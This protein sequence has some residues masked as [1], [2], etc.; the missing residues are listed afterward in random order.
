MS[1][2]VV[3]NRHQDM[4]RKI[5]KSKLIFI[6]L[7]AALLF[8]GNY[9]SKDNKVEQAEAYGNFKID[10]FSAKASQNIV[11]TV[12]KKN[13]TAPKKFNPLGGGI[14]KSGSVLAKTKVIDGMRVCKTNNDHPQKSS[15]NK[16][17]HIDGECCLDP[18]E[19]PNALCYYPQER[20]GKMLQKY[21][22]KAK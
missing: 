21:L 9:A 3:G 5:I 7:A 12:A 15:K 16:P 4:K 20:Y 22:K 8:A 13:P 10:N 18:D 11:L 14:G 1:D 17:G 6:F 2:V 19:T